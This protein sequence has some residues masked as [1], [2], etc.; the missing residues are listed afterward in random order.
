MR[1][2]LLTLAIGLTAAHALATSYEVGPGRS[3]TAIGDVPWESLAPGDTVFIAKGGTETAVNVGK[4]H[5][6]E[7]CIE[8]K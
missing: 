7:I 3:F 6:R 2:T 5:W 1:Y 8:L 4:K